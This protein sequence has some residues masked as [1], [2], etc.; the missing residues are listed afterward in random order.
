[1]RAAQ[2]RSLCVS[3]A[4]LC[5]GCS[6]KTPVHAAA[7]PGSAVTDGQGYAGATRK[8]TQ[9]AEKTDTPLASPLPPPSAQTVPLPPPTPKKVRKPKK[10]K[11]AD[12]PPVTARW[13]S[14]R[15]GQRPPATRK[16]LRR[17][18][19]NR[20]SEQ[21]CHWPIDNRGQRLGRK[22]QA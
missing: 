12:T 10:P 9:Q 4:I 20:G 6:H 13:V 19:Y 3:L 5:T 16:L 22:N 7:S 8:T 2:L 1:M 17:H 14:K 11:P 18:S 21:L 15:P